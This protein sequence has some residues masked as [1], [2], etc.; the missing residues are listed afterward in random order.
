MFKIDFLFLLPVPI[1]TSGIGTINYFEHS[2]RRRFLKSSSQTEN[3]K[4][5]RPKNQIDETD[6]IP[7]SSTSTARCA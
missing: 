1:F 2:W 6:F 4:I 3:L 5:E 7:V